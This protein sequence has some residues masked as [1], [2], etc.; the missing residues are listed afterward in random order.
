MTLI[1]DGNGTRWVNVPPRK[2]R[3]PAR[4]LRFAKIAVGDV[5]LHRARYRSTRYPSGPVPTAN[6]N[7][8]ETV[9]ETHGFA[10]VEHLWTDP[11][12]GEK[13]PVAGQMVGLRPLTQHGRAGSLTGMPIRGLASQ[14]YHP[15]SAAHSALV[16]AFVLDRE[17]LVRR[18]TEG[19]I[20]AAEARAQAQPW[21]A[22]L[23]D[24]GLENDG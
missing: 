19:S 23:R 13:D 18:F 17:E 5:L 1:T 11:V 4:A 7:P 24:L 16:L 21:R 10:I 14:G 20:T 8:L 15:L 22:L 6:D 12:R 2:R 3:K 9:H